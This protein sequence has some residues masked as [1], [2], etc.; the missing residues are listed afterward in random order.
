MP[1]WAVL[2][3]IW[4]QSTWGSAYLFYLF[5]DVHHMWGLVSMGSNHESRM[6][7]PNSLLRLF[8][9]C[10]KWLC[11]HGCHHGHSHVLFRQLMQMVCCGSAFPSPIIADLRCQTMTRQ[12]CL[13]SV[14]EALASTLTT[15]E[16]RV[17]CT[18]IIPATSEV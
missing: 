15:A 18:L 17:W 10:M 9:C 16:S 12:E 3:G 8:M 6:L 2:L 7:Y 5:A 14:Q 1:T 4:I 11:F 13:S